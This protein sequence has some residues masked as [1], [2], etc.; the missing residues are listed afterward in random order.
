MFDRYFTAR[1]TSWVRSVSGFWTISLILHGVALIVFI[2]APLLTIKLVPAPALPVTLFDAP[3]PPPPPPPP[4]KKKAKPQVKQEQPKPTPPPKPSQL[5][6][7][8]KVPEKLPEP[9]PTNSDTGGADT[10]D[11]NGVE[12]GV[13]GGVTGGVPQAAPPPEPEQP[14]KLLVREPKRLAAGPIAYPPAARSQHATGVVAARICTD[15]T[16]QVREI[17]ILK[18]APLF[19]GAVRDAVLG[20]RYEPTYAGSTPI[21]VC[22]PAYFNFKLQE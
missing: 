15:A 5:V 20:W 14:K 22:F 16:G 2:V 19:D 3:P 12:G 8:E 9:E 1:K 6:E 11:E 21:P 4:K 17:T 7:P 10:G 13:E 18:S